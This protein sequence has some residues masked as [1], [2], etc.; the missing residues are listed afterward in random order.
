M[1]VLN[2]AQQRLYSLVWWPNLLHGGEVPGLEEEG[3][4][5]VCELG[6]PQLYIGALRIVVLPA[7][8]RRHFRCVTSETQNLDR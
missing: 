2:E 1:C 6:A 8:C 3:C 5:Y 4:W 7:T